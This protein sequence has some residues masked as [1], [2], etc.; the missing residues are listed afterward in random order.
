MWHVVIA[1][2]LVLLPYDLA[3]AAVAAVVVV[4]GSICA[5]ASVCLEVKRADGDVMV[6]ELWFVARPY[7]IVGSGFLPPSCRLFL[8]LSFFLSVRRVCL[9]CC[10]QQAASLCCCV[11]R[12]CEMACPRV[13]VTVEKLLCLCQLSTHT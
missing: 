6:L 1:P 2:R 11:E 4:V 5:C 8:S 7:N 13:V 3:A 9:T 12:V 10:P